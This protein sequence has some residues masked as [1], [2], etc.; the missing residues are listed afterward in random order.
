[1]FYL[2]DIATIKEFVTDSEEALAAIQEDV[3]KS[4][5]IHGSITYVEYPEPVIEPSATNAAM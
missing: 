3:Q 1:M 4:V 2:G 5:W